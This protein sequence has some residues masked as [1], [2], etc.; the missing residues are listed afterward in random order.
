M[1]RQVGKFL[2]Q[3]GDE[4]IRWKEILE[5]PYQEYLLNK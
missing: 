4:I 5:V 1:M 3:I 2:H